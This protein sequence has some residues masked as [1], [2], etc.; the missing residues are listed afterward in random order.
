MTGPR[1]RICYLLAWFHPVSSGAERQALAQGVELVRRGHSI[2]VLTRS[3]PGSDL[4][5]DDNLRG[6]VVRR[7]IDPIRRGP[8]FGVSFV[9]ETIRS[10]LRL[11]P[12]YDL[13]HTHQALWEAVSTGL[14]RDIIRAPVLVQPAS[15]GYFGEAE[16]LS[17]TKGFPILRRLATRNLRFAAISEDIERQWRSLGVPRDRI[18]RTASGV[19]RSI[20]YPGASAVEDGLPPRPRVLFTGRLHPQKNLSGLILNWPTIFE[21]TGASLILL[22]SGPD[23]DRLQSLASE[24]GI[25]HAVHFIDA[26]D[27]PSEYLR[28]ADL[29]VLPSVAEGMSNSLLEAMATGLPCIASRI[30]GNVDLLGHPPAGLLVAPDDLEGWRTA[31]LELLEQDNAADELSASAQRVIVE[32]HDLALIV[33]RYE[34]VYREMIS[35]RT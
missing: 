20:F 16:E 7:W 8:M 2:Q 15:S 32:R 11:R 23:R 24:L 5:R 28:A 6:V 18:I 33:D 34:R 29:F 26:V 4:P 1:L 13:I 30:G 3:V 27:D 35:E 12:T 19:D 31:I 22:G 25:G 17:R 21:K 14:G 9:A 10:L